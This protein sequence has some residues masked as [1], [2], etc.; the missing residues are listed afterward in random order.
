[1][2]SPS[3]RESTSFVFIMALAK[4]FILCDAARSW[5]YFSVAAIRRH[6]KADIFKAKE[7]AGELGD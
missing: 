6:N 1:M 4:G 3:V 5:S 7:L 2:C